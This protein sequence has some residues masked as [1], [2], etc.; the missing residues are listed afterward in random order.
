VNR[1]WAEGW[2]WGGIGK[3]VEVGVRLEVGGVRMSVGVGC[4]SSGVGYGTGTA[5]GKV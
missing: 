4:G 3:E 1:C 2:C 5:E